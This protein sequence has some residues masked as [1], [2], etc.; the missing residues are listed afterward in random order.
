MVKIFF[1]VFFLIFFSGVSSASEKDYKISCKPFDL[2]S[3]IRIKENSLNGLYYHPFKSD[4]CFFLLFE[5]DNFFDIE[6]IN[7]DY[8]NDIIVQFSIF[9]TIK[10]LSVRTVHVD[11]KNKI[12][13]FMRFSR[14]S[15]VYKNAEYHMEL[16]EEYGL[17]ADTQIFYHE[18]FH[19]SDDENL[20]N[21]EIY[22][23]VFGL[24]NVL[25]F[26]NIGYEDFYNLTDTVKTLRFTSYGQ[27]K[28]TKNPLANFQ[29]NLEDR[30][31]FYKIKNEVNNCSNFNCLKAYSLIF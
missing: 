21:S 26:S 9:N 7:E 14:K 11:T 17:H 6:D 29:E 2:Y 19:L 1:I 12:F 8:H 27:K 5:E 22:A 18:I 20:E 28:N 13:S 25:K 3:S 30:V 23:D 10:N 16:F 31:K 4:S 24:L 15:S